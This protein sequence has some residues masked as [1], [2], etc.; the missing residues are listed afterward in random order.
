MATSPNDDVAPATSVFRE[1]GDLPTRARV[2]VSAEAR[3]MPERLGKLAGHRGF[4]D[5]GGAGKQVVANRL[6]HFAQSRT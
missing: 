3:C 1:G 5:T 4:A 6:F 2:I